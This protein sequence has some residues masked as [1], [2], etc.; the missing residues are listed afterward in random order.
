MWYK[1]YVMYPD[2]TRL[3]TKDYEPSKMDKYKGTFYIQLGVAFEVNLNRT[4]A[5]GAR[6]TYAYFMN[7]YTDGRGYATDAALASKNNDGIFLKRSIS[8]F[9]AYQGTV[10]IDVCRA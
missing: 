10:I 9:F 7:D 3:H 5:V 4:F 1:N 6:A 8:D 2:Y